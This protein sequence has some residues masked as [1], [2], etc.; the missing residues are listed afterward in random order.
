MGRMDG[1]SLMYK[2]VA[3]FEKSDMGPLVAA[4]HDEI[5]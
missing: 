3:G 1:L 5:V 4:M 2:V